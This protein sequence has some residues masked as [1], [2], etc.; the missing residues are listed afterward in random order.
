MLSSYL[1]LI[2]IVETDLNGRNHPGLEQRTQ[3]AIGYCVGDEMK[4]E[5]VSPGK[6]KEKKEKGFIPSRVKP[7]LVYGLV[8]GSKAAVSSSNSKTRAAL[9]IQL[10]PNTYLL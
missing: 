2:G 4:V 3:D 9:L 6:W 5:R 8:F 10:N 1:E 7:Y